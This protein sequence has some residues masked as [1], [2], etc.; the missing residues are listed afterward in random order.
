MVLI[1]HVHGHLIDYARMSRRV[2]GPMV[3]VMDH[4]KHDL[5]YRCSAAEK[6]PFPHA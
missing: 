3:P 4:A 5:S 1:L 6:R 2:K